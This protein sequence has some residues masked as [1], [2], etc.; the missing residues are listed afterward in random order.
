MTLA[1]TRSLVD[2]AAERGGAV[3]SFNV[4]T[5]DNAEAIV[6]GAEQAG[7]GVLLQ[8]S[9]NALAWHG[10][11][12]PI[13]AAC[14]ELALAAA[15]PIGIHLDH[16]QDDALVER[17]LPRA[18]ELGVGS[19]MYDASKLAYAD[20]VTATTTLARRAQQ[21]G[22]W[23]EAELGEIG[24]KD[25]AHAPGVRT[26]PDEARAFVEATGVD[27]LA[28]AVGSS[29]AMRDRSAELDIAL[30]RELALRVSVPLV[31]HGS[32]GVSDAGIADAVR[33]G[34]RKVNVGTALSI[35]STAALRSSLAGQPD[36]VDPRKYSRAA[37]S[38]TAALVAHL[39]EVIADP[40]R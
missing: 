39:C 36:A 10:A 1:S 16:I 37:R 32:S 18:V 11:P 14:R 38:D 19:I 24:G 6:A 2:D 12:E 40:A 20:N 17:M 33:A 29:H 13:L 3:P 4:I 35:A 22:L 30:I 28:V 21:L 9:E 34:I 23:V 26:H 5:L 7:C 31:L 25:G 15:V 27:G 8:L